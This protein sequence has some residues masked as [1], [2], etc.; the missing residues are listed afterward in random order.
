MLVL[1][2]KPSMA[3]SDKDKSIYFSK[4]LNEG[5][6]LYFSD[7]SKLECA[8]IFSNEGNI[9]ADEFY[10]ALN[11]A[12]NNFHYILYAD[13]YAFSYI[14]AIGKTEYQCE[15]GYI[16]KYRKLRY[17]DISDVRRI[18]N[19]DENL[20]S[21]EYS[22]HIIAA[23]EDVSNKPIKLYIEDVDVYSLADIIAEFRMKYGFPII[24]ML[25]LD[26]YLI[27]LFDEFIHDKNK[28]TSNLVEILIEKNLIKKT[29]IFFV[30]FANEK[31]FE[32]LKAY[33]KGE[34]L[35]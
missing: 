3:F 34:K 18:R 10:S 9:K 2:I 8:I 33:L 15:H 22:E 25:V 29:S 23:S 35:N 28:V 30:A 26:D 4:I 14:V 17:F 27:L 32:A 21:K 5:I 6:P 31:D 24:E 16:R 20:S 13:F 12:Y 11:Q 19:Y 1:L 7:I